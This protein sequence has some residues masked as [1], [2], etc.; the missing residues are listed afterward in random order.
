MYF[1]FR[2]NFVYTYNGKERQ[3]ITKADLY[4]PVTNKT[5]T[6]ATEV[7]NKHFH[8]LSTLILQ[9]LINQT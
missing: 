7:D 5:L 9:F 6:V 3:V 1:F 8:R 2:L 4:L